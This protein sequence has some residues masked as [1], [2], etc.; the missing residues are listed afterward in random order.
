[1]K[2]I[3]A[4]ILAALMILSVVACSTDKGES[5]PSVDATTGTDPKRTDEETHRVKYH[6]HIS[7]G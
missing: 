5:K 2:K 6:H 7:W 4:I 1:M 3:L